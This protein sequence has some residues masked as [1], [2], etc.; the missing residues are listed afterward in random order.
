MTSEKESSRMIDSGQPVSEFHSSKELDVHFEQLV[1][2]FQ[3]CF[4]W[5]KD[6]FELVTQVVYYFSLEIVLLTFCRT[7]FEEKEEY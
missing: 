1:G 4:E 6:D 5:F 7:T 3:W 2:N